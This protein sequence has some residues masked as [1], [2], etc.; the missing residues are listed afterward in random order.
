MGGGE[1]GVAGCWL[2]FSYQGEGVTDLVAVWGISGIIKQ[3][4]TSTL[5]N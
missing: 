5:M 1:M 4:V 3:C 2:L